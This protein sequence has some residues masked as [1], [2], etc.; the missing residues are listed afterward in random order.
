MKTLQ[1]LQP[2]A[3]MPAPMMNVA[4]LVL[5]VMVIAGGIAFNVVAAVLT[6]ILMSWIG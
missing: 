6:G 1:F 4:R 2:T 5:F 3:N